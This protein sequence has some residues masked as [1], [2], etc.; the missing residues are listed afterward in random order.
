MVTVATALQ[1]KNLAPISVTPGTSVLE[2]LQVMAD[3]NIGSLVVMENETYLGIVTE[4]DYSRKVA[5]KGKNSQSTT[6]AEIM[7]TD[8]PAVTPQD[9]VEKCMELMSE[10]NV[11]YLPVLDGGKLFGIISMTDLV[12]ETILAQKET[13]DQLKNYIHS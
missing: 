10:K 1:R 11:R 2:A 5:L 12:K 7:S 8:L 13:I 4:R 9:K 3:R 6:V